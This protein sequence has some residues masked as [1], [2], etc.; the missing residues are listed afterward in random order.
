MTDTVGASATEE[1]LLANAAGTAGAP[2][3]QVR[4][5]TKIAHLY[6]E[7][8]LRQNEIA[9]ML[10]ISQAKVSRLLKRASEVGIVRTVVVLSQGVHTDLE[11]ALEERYGLLEAV[12]A[13]VTGDEVAVLAGLGSAGASYL[14]ATLSGGERIGVSSWSQTLLAVVDRLRQRRASGAESVVQLVGGIGAGAAQAQ[15]NRLL[16]EF[17]HLV[18]ASPSYVPAP[19]LVG[20]AAMRRDLMAEPAVRSVTASWPDLTMALVGIG[21]LQPSELLQRSGNA[22]DP[23]DQAALLELGAVGDVCHRFFDASGR[24]VSSELDARVVGIDPDSFRTIPR[25][26]GLAGGERKHEAIRAAVLGRWVNVLLTDLS[27]ARALLAD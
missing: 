23:A 27:T 15:A 6:H 11:R 10:H 20:G 18:G 17:A 24:H 25:R 8:N 21:S 5:M 1:A 26:I 22:I 19:G 4:L 13:D 3:G 2:D 14:E 7:Q 12:V 16:S 9:A